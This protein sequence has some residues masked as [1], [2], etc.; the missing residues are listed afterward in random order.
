MSPANNDT[1]VQLTKGPREVTVKSHLSEFWGASPGQPSVLEREF[2]FATHWWKALEDDQQTD[3]LKPMVAEGTSGLYN[4]TVWTL[5]R[6]V[7]N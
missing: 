7:L 5:K 2:Y 3:N 6:N 1:E 4:A